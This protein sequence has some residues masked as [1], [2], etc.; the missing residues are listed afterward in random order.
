MAKKSRPTF[1]KLNKERARQ[2]KQ[3]A[4]AARRLEA[5]QRRANAA[6]EMG[7]TTLDVGDIRADPQP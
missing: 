5:K 1:Q 2:Q 4:K 7:E 3:Q 6:S